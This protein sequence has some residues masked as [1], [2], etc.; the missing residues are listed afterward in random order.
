LNS[1]L[2]KRL[3][4]NRQGFRFATLSSAILA[5]AGFAGGIAGF[6]AGKVLARIVNLRK[7]AHGIS[8]ETA[9]KLNILFPGMEFSNILIIDNAWLPAHLFDRSIEGMTFHNRIYVTH[10]EVQYTQ[11]GFML[12]VH[13]LVHVKQ[14]RESGEFI[15]ACKYGRQFI[16]Y[17]GYSRKMPYEYEA[18]EFVE[19][20]RY[21]MPD[22]S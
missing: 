3:R 12:L 10:R 1:D 15:F 17:G 16:I 8:P 21:R 22:I 19:K 4:S 11:A 18:Y 20:N 5:F 13:E 2:D 6:Y 9:K 7:T 14:T